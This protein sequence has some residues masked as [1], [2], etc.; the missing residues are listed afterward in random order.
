MSKHSAGLAD[1]QLSIIHSYGINA[2]PAQVICIIYINVLNIS[3]PSWFRA[4]QNAYL[5][6]ILP[7]Q[8]IYNDNLI[9][10]TTPCPVDIQLSLIVLTYTVR[11]TSPSDIHLSIRCSHVLNIPLDHIIHCTDIY[12]LTSHQQS[13]ITAIHNADRTFKSFHK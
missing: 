13:W 12:V 2:P 1:I 4:I 6:N 11:H 10:Y 3:K 7:A 8:F 9:F 5:L